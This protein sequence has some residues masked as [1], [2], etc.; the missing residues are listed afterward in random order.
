MAIS[1]ANATKINHM[2]RASHN[3]SL[4]TVVQNL[5][6]GSATLN[7]YVRASGSFTAGATEAAGSKVD[8]LTGLTGVKGYLVNCY[9]SGS[10]MTGIVVVNSGSNLL[11]TGGSKV[12]G[13]PKAFA[14]G[15]IV[16]W[17]VW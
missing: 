4:G 12:A 3:V 13:T 17:I 9:T 11:V 5:Q 16:N 6:S 1:D 7:T 8:V 15:D 2:N 10:L 14:S